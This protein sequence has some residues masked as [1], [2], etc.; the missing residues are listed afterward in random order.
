MTLDQGWKASRV[1]RMET[2][3]ACRLGSA[4]GE[5]RLSGKTAPKQAF[6]L[7]FSN[8]LLVSQQ[9]VKV[10]SRDI[11]GENVLTLVAGKVK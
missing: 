9:T 1:G 10:L 8:N 2:N 11:S 3:Y 4:K 6:P 5:N 7:H